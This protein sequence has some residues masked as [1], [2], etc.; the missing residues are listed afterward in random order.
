MTF[1]K[2]N[3]QTGSI[4]NTCQG[5]PHEFFGVMLYEASRSFI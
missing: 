4:T 2:K 5:E 3:A 1:S